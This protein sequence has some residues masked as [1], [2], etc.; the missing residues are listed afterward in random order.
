MYDHYEEYDEEYELFAENSGFL[1]NFNACQLPQY[2]A[3]VDAYKIVSP[4]VELVIGTGWRNCE[5][6]L[7]VKSNTQDLG[8]FWRLFETFKGA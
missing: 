7:Y 8:E 2:Q 5:H 1:T 6:A 3:A 4:A